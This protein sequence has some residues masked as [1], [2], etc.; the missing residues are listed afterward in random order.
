MNRS[1][2][3]RIAFGVLIILSA[4][5]HSRPDAPEALQSPL[6]DGTIISGGDNPNDDMLAPDNRGD[7]LVLSNNV[8]FTKLDNDKSKTSRRYRC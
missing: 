2:R 4:C 7:V 8:D 6:P 3:I 5:A 1:L